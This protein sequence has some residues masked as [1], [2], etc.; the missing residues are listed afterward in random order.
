MARKT[1]T[2]RKQR[3]RDSAE[4]RP[5]SSEVLARHRS[6]GSRLDAWENML[7]GLGTARDKR[8]GGR[9]ASQFVTYGEAEA[10]WRGDHMAA[11]VVEEPAREMTRRWL[12]VPVEGDKDASEGMGAALEVLKAQNRVR[13]A[14]ERQR[15]FGGAG[16]Y[17]GVNDGRDPSQPLNENAVRSFD[18]MTVFDPQELIPRRYYSDVFDPEYGKPERYWLYPQG[19]HGEPA[20]EVK[21]LGGAEVHASRILR[22]EGIF[23]TRRQT[24]ENYGW[25]DPIF[26]RMLQVLADFGMSFGGAAH[27]MQDFA[28]AVWKIRGLAEALQSNEPEL[29][30]QRLEIMEVAR[31]L[32]RAVPL[33]AGDG[34]GGPS[35]EF[36]RKATPVTGLP[37]LL[38]R[39]CNL[40]ASAVDMPVT[41]LMGQAP[42]GLN[43]TGA[44][45][46][47]WWRDKI[48]GLQNEVIRDPMER[49]IRLAFLSK[50]GPTNG[51]E[52]E[53]WSLR[54]RP[55]AELSGLDEATR[56]KT[57]VDMAKAAV[58]A[59]MIM[60]EE[61]AVSIFGG[62]E[63]SQDIH[64]DMELRKK[65]AAE[66]P[67]TEEPPMPGKPSKPGEPGTGAP[68]NAA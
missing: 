36:E 26:A 27:L 17:L 24:A 40:L 11:K 21:N 63:F 23:I 29:I 64:L 33:D 35:E 28:Q 68:P 13:Q 39:M 62:D 51:K 10:L 4:P 9:V 8:M 46:V 43:A 32:L 42:A 44:A 50:S 2:I 54:F 1:V 6:D 31:S 57:I 67:P 12:D 49:V 47:G 5:S 7:T 58:D 37:E 66:P 15:A 14:I 56:R 20:H 48:S 65:M 45:D 34:D 16:I 60:P 38:D 30:R 18:F 25:G 52:P 61:A 55:L 22:F 53:N 41:R 59:Q 19:I 3:R